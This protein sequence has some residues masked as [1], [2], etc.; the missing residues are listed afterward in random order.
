MKHRQTTRGDQAFSR[1]GSGYSVLDHHTTPDDSGSLS[2][3]DTASQSR[4]QRAELA[5]RSRRWWFHKDCPPKPG[6]PLFSPGLAQGDVE[7]IR[8]ARAHGGHVHRDFTRTRIVLFKHNRAGGLRKDNVR[9]GPGP[10]T[11]YGPIIESADSILT[12]C[13]TAT[14]HGLMRLER[15]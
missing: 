1:L 12:R 11:E 13:G 10:G 8:F 15:R 14:G 6:H 4:N 7:H 5:M 2:A 3:H 9:A